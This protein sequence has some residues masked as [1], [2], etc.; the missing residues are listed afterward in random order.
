MSSLFSR[1]T[2]Q[3]KRIKTD[4]RKVSRLD[5]FFDLIYVVLIRDLFHVMVGD[6]DVNIF[7]KITLIF[8]PVWLIRQWFNFYIQ[9]FEESTI[10]HRFL[11]FALM[12]CVG[13]Y[14]YSVHK[15]GLEITPLLLGAWIVGHGMLAY[16]FWSA[17]HGMNKWKVGKV[18]N[19]I[20]LNHV[21][22]VLLR[23]VWFFVPWEMFFS[24]ILPLSIFL[25]LLSNLLLPFISSRLPSIHSG[26]LWERYGLFVIIVLAELIYGLI[27]WLSDAWYVSW[28]TI[29]LVV[30]W[31]VSAIAIWRT[32]FD[33]IWHNPLKKNA[34]KFVSHRTFLHLP[35]SLA[36]IFLW[37][38]FLHLI[39]QT[40][41]SVMNVTLT[42]VTW[43]IF[44][45]M[46]LIIWCMS[47]FHTFEYT[48]PRYKLW[49]SDHLPGIVMIWEMIVFQF[50]LLLFPLHDPLILVW[51][52]LLMYVINIFLFHKFFDPLDEDEGYY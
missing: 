45:C 49:W 15:F 31:F 21:V 22:F 18:P 19:R 20:I 50:L 28:E 8:T 14:S 16:M 38:M 40:S 4:H 29:M 36:I 47:F 30:M 3:M 17:I 1:D 23:W 52:V 5:L 42:Y 9:R 25:S 44:S 7:R 35:L 13:V 11:T 12:A 39:F 51:L 6:V 27:L 32:Y 41:T 37:G 26:H 48:H 2:P 24:R 43:G 46:L 33:I 10:R 34:L